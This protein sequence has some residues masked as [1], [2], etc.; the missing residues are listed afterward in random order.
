M[1]L[2]LL[3]TMVTLCSLSPASDHD[4]GERNLKG[5]SLNLTDLYVFREDWQTAGGSPD[6]LILIMNTNP[7]SVAR[8]QYE[9]STKARYEFHFTSVGSKTSR[10]TGKNDFTLSF[11]FSPVNS[12]GRQQITMRVQDRANLFTAD[13]PAGVTSPLNTYA[14]NEVRVGSHELQVFAGLREDPFFF[15]VERYLRIRGLLATGVNT[16]GNGSIQ[17]GANVFRSDATAVDFAA[18]YNVNAIVV[19][20]PLAMLMRN[21]ERVFDVWET[22]SVGGVQLERLARPAIN[23]G[24]LISNS[25]LNTFNAIPPRLDLSQAAAPVA[26]QAASVL[27]AVNKYGTSAGLPAPAVADVAT[28]FFPDVMR[29]DTSRSVSIGSWAYNSDAVIVDGTTS[30]AMLTGG[31]KLEDDVMDITLSYL[32]AGNPACGPSQSCTIPD[33]VSYAGG[34]SCATAGTG[35][36]PGNPGHK[37]LH[38]QTSRNGSA[39]FPFLAKAN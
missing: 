11:T 19:R 3:L 36:N 33:G 2:F 1:K 18:G 31:R 30:A 29:I 16:L 12:Q 7:R 8:Q 27:D 35:S 6:H 10:P 13:I 32:I 15:D 37:C 39:T 20:L 24:L 28:G 26:S 14:K 21:K 23:E 5:R 22:I 34:T 38:G 25:L 17:G 9:F 4:D